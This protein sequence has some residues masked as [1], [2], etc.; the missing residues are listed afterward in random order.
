MESFRQ[1]VALG[2][3]AIELDVRL[4]RDGQVVVF[5]DPTL[6][7]TVGQPQ[8]VAEVTLSALRA[9]DAGAHFTPDGGRTW[10][11]RDRGVQVPTLA[12]V[13]ESFPHLP[14]IIEIKCV[15][16]ARPVLDL[17][18]AMHATDRCVL[19]SFRAEVHGVI[20]G[21]GVPRAASI[22]E[23]RSLYLPA[24]LGARR[25][26]L[27]FESMSLPPFYR[28]IPVPLG[29]LTR[30]ASPA[31][32]TMHVWVVNQAQEARRLWQ[33][34]VHGILSDDP[35]VILAARGPSGPQGTATASSEIG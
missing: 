3:D 30:L 8:A 9:L 26:Q 19:G 11:W 5:H 29:A 23:I 4:T 17:L 2:V 14:L 22:A 10:P 21:A 1:A 12:E 20:T 7:R 34:G 15:E 33:R 32:A 13:L 6:E 35:A 31:G 24:L 25:H 16:A 27:P 18:R 28:G